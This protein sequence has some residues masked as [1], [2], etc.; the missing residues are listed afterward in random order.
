M[1]SGASFDYYGLC[2]EIGPQGFQGAAPRGQIGTDRGINAVL[3]RRGPGIPYS[4][5]I[6]GIPGIPGM[7]P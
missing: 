1:G 5:G 2:C 4:I 3:D 6:L 7:G